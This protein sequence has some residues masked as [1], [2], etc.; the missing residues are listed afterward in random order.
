MGERNV[1][2][3]EEVDV[4]QHEPVNPRFTFVIACFLF[5]IFF[6]LFIAAF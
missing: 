5:A 4:N 3:S 6:A 2:V 1:I